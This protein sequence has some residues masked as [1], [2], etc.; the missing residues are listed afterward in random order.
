MILVLFKF[1]ET[2]IW[3]GDIRD[4][5][6]VSLFYKLVEGLPHSP[7]GGYGGPWHRLIVFFCGAQRIT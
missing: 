1:I 7:G 3:R 2:M 5:F 6:P 4:N